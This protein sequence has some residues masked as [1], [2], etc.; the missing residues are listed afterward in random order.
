MN[1]GCSDGH[2]RSGGVEKAKM[3][4]ADKAV[5]KENK[6]EVV[7]EAVVQEEEGGRGEEKGDD[8]REDDDLEDEDYDY[9]AWHDYVRNDCK[10]D[11]DDDFEGG[12]PKHS[13][14]GQC[15][16]NLNGQS[17]GRFCKTKDSGNSVSGRRQSKGGKRRSNLSEQHCMVSGSEAY[18]DAGIDYIVTSRTSGTSYSLIQDNDEMIVP[19]ITKCTSLRSGRGWTT[20]RDNV[21]RSSRS[22]GCTPSQGKFTS[23]RVEDLLRTPSK[24]Y[25]H[26]PVVIDDDED[27]D[28]PFGECRVD[29]VEVAFTKGQETFRWRTEIDGSSFPEEKET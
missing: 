10:T 19:P 13:S 17:G 24:E 3:C 25:K 9:D 12:P 4:A 6:K 7:V 1:G 18:T 27:T 2:P 20:E 11:S 15:R 22:I 26:N 28:H 29:E 14:G 5:D 16:R 8:I 23:E 21:S